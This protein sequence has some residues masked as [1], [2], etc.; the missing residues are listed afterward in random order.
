MSAVKIS[1]S[2][3]RF[4]FVVWCALHPAFAQESRPRRP[5]R[6]PPP[7]PEHRT[8]GERGGPQGDR[9]R[10]GPERRDRLW[11]E[12]VEAMSDG[13]RRA[14]QRLPQAEKERAVREAVRR[15]AEKEEAAFMAGLGD[16]EKA[17]L[18][19]LKDDPIRRR[20]RLVELRVARHFE[21]AAEEAEAAGLVDETEIERLRAAPLLRRVEA[22]L[23]LRKRVFLS[24]HKADF[25]GLPD[26]ERDRLSK[27]PAD[28][29]F[30]DP[31]VRDFKS[32]RFL[33]PAEIARARAADAK[34]VRAFSEALHDGRFDAD[35]AAKLFSKE[36]AAALEGLDPEAKRRVARD[37]RRYALARD[38]ERGFALPPSLMDELSEDEAREVLRL[39]GP[40]RRAFA[41]KRF[42]AKKLFE[43]RRDA[44]L[45]RLP[46]RVRERFRELADDEQKRLV[47]LPG[48]VLRRELF[49]RF[50]N[51]GPPPPP[52]DQ[53]PPPPHRR[54][55]P[56][57]K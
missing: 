42:G 15:R 11:R 5:D 28:R 54:P 35:G 19:A 57:R 45:E 32:F 10:M 47:E 9:G 38:D 53:G 23:D 12:V 29:F 51:D 21:L 2:R 43:A 22:T 56:P 46:P 55:P 18:E 20:A 44:L 3:L 41:L 13:E 36:R 17:E 48:S 33:V 39:P 40:A 14:F 34:A 37:L 49:D 1:S 52:P 30:D 50:P 16:A 4:A 26:R 25:E 31:F 24:A 7:R 6:E 8:D 27:T